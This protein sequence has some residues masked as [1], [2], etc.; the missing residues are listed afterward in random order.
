MNY[1][2]YYET[3]GVS[4]GSSTDEIQKAYRKLARKYHPDI[5]KD[6]GAEDRFKEIAEAY[7]VLKDPEK[8]GRYD[9][10]GSAWKQAQQTGG[11]P[12]GW[13]HVF[14]GGGQGGVRFE[15]FGDSGFSSFFESLF[16]AGAGGGGFQGRG[17]GFGGAPRSR[18]R[19]A[20]REA[21]L[22]VSLEEAA[23]GGERTLTF[24]DPSNGEEVRLKVRIPPGVAP[25]RKI[26]I[27]GKG[28]QGPQGA[29]D[30]YV[31]IDVR[32]HPRLRLEGADVFTSLDLAPWEAAL[33]TTARIETLDGAVTVKVPGG[34]SS[35]Q[36]I[37]LRGKGFP[38]PGGVDG[39]LYVELRIVMPKSLTERE[40]ELFETLAEVSE[41]EAR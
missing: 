13:E 18:G 24:T 22:L 7:E 25:G 1:K 35:G 5:N 29:G 17:A 19:G 16:G 27:A 21:R 31:Q 15:D 40:R 38:V 30:L 12:P 33:G 26:R 23:R 36:R 6:A 11:A 3:L 32:P 10:F 20:D 8:R 4:R 41:F 37:R 14:H 9:Q 39:D 28:Y 2:D 34:A